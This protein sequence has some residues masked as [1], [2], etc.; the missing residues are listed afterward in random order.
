MMTMMTTD[1]DST[2]DVES[3]RTGE[4]D[5]EGSVGTCATADHFLAFSDSR[6][7]RGA[8]VTSRTHTTCKSLIPQWLR[9]FSIPKYSSRYILPVSEAKSFFPSR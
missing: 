4:D 7:A 9:L 2:S 8:E 5:D 1:C 6:T 3:V